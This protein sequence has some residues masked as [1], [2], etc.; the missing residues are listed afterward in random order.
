MTTPG[1]PATPDA[2]TLLRQLLTRPAAEV[3]AWLSSNVAPPDFNWLGLAEAAGSDTLRASADVTEALTWA[4]VARAA[5]ERLVAG[6][7]GH[8]YEPGRAKLGDD[9]LRAA[10]ITRY[11][12]VPGDAFLDC[13]EL[14]VS[15]LARHDVEFDEVARDSAQWTTLPIERIR[16]MRYIKNELSVLRGLDQCERFADPAIQRWLALWPQLP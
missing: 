16:D 8:P 10:L 6:A 14:F 11:G 1:G 13:D 7:G 9:N 2:N 5:R 3:E 4:R 15:F 12:S